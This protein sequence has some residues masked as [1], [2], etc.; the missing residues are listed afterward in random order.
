MIS[1]NQ[2]DSAEQSMRAVIEVRNRD[3]ERDLANRLPDGV[4]L[5]GVEQSDER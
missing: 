1:N 2:G 5:V 3:A 4:R